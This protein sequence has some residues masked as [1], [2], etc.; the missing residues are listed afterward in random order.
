MMREDMP[1]NDGS[2]N[3]VK[4]RIPAW[5]WVGLAVLLLLGVIAPRISLFRKPDS[6]TPPNLPVVEK[7]KAESKALEPWAALD[8]E[9]RAFCE[10]LPE[11][12]QD[13]QNRLLTAFNAS[14]KAD[15]E[16]RE[17]VV[18]HEPKSIRD[19]QDDPDAHS[20]WMAAHEAETELQVA[21]AA[22]ERLGAVEDDLKALRRGVRQA[23]VKRGA[24]DHTVSSLREQLEKMRLAAEGRDPEQRQAAEHKAEYTL[25]ERVQPLLENK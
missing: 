11:L 17:W 8:D 1:A 23:I 18:Q 2:H 24:V 21:V 15:Q 22:R 5:C 3:P 20:K 16:L 6:P 7:I 4:G 19:I 12:R 25:T 14:A 9:I 13:G 10:S